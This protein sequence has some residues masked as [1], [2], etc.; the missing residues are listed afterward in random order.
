MQHISK[1]VLLKADCAKRVYLKTKNAK[2]MSLS[3]QLQQR[4]FT[5]LQANNSASKES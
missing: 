3:F 4:L 2:F 1:F 5:S